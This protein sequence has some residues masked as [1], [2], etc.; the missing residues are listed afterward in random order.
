MHI[1]MVNHKFSKTQLEH[2]F[3]FELSEMNPEEVKEAFLNISI[4]SPNAY[5]SQNDDNC[6]TEEQIGLKHLKVSYLCLK[7]FRKLQLHWLT[8]KTCIIKQTQEV[9]IQNTRSVY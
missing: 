4:K 2:F 3:V 1:S 9:N 6:I 8:A 5:Y 7:P